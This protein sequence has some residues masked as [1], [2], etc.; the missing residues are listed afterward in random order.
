MRY[1]R[2]KAV[3]VLV[4]LILLVLMCSEVQ[5]DAKAATAQQQELPADQ[6]DTT[7]AHTYGS[8]FSPGRLL[9]K[10]I[11]GLAGV[12]FL[13]FL[14]GRILSGRLGLPAGS[15]R[16]LSVLDSLPL[17]SGKGLIIIQ[18]GK[19]H[20]LLGIGG[21]RIDML[22]ELEETDL[23]ASAENLSFAGVLTQ[24]QGTRQSN[25]QQTTELIQ[26]QIMRLRRNDHREREGEGE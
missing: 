13:L 23:V 7:R 1:S 2:D 19:K 6:S 14:L 25:W 22:T 26:R 3:R 24:A 9:L 11:L 18:V 16:Y 15:A 10:M 12:L 4:I 8:A 20:Y 17:G 21:E 5:S